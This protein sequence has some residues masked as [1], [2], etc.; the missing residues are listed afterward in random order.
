M[1]DNYHQPVMG[2][3][4]FDEIFLYFGD[5]VYFSDSNGNPLT[6]PHNQTIWAG[7]PVDEIE[8][9]NPVAGTN[10][11]WTQ[12][13]Y[14]GFGNN[15]TSTGVYGGGS[16]V[17]CS[18]TSQPGVN[19]IVTYLGSLTPAISPNCDPGHYYLVNNYNPGYFGDGRDAYTDT[20]PNNTPFTIS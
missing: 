8:N 19:Q 7:G 2:G 5:A 9:P 1:S 6:P 11:W 15:G 20:N 16:Y 13:G 12:D 17:D 18:D 14:G 10:N 3:T 4:G